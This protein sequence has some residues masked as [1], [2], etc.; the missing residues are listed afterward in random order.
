MADTLGYFGDARLEK[1]GAFLLARLHEYGMAGVSGARLGAGRAGQMRITRFLH[2]SSVRS[3]EMIQTAAGRTATQVQGRH[4]LAIQDTTTLRDDGDRRSLCLHPTIAMD[5]DTGVLYGLV[6]AEYL[7]H[8]GGKR[9]GRKRRPFH[10]KESRRWLTST[11]K[12]GALRLAGAS[13]VTVVADREGDIYEEFAQRP[14]HV[15]LVIRAGQDR[16]LTTGGLLFQ[17]LATAPVLGRVNVTLPAHANREERVAT[18]EIRVCAVSLSCPNRPLNEKRKLPATVTVT[19]IEAREIKPPEGVEPAHWRLL[20]THPVTTLADAVRVVGYYR[21][22]WTIEQ[23]FRTMKT[24]GFQ[25]EA[26]QV[27]DED[28]FENLAMAILIAAIRVMQM[29]AERDAAAARP[30]TDVFEPEDAPVLLALSARLEGKTDR[31]KNPHPVGSLGHAVWVIARLGG[32][33][34]YYRKPGPV[35]I[36]RGWNR[37]NA[38]KFGWDTRENVR[39]P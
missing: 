31:Q 15:E 20:T 13:Q 10:S 12:A 30:L 11:R 7:R 28:A 23:V 21:A 34:G 19:A 6:H 37:F 2:N 9:N 24:Q 25:V 38:I 27:R 18:L 14:A 39:I 4:I 1:G 26:V 5:A 17:T 22:R 36:M 3:S 29:V 35:I 32:W 16:R 33:T 8:A